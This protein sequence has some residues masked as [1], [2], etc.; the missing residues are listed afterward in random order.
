[1]TGIEPALSAWELACHALPTTVFAAQSK[2]ALSVS[3]RYRPPQ[4]MA[5]G[6]QRARCT[7]EAFW[8]QTS[9]APLLATKRRSTARALMPAWGSHC[10]H[11]LLYLAAV[12]D[13]RRVQEHCQGRIDTGPASLAAPQAATSQHRNPRRQKLKLN[14]DFTLSAPDVTSP[15]VTSRLLCDVDAVRTTLP[16]V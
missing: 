13:D 12:R 3:A 10:A 15:V 7:H 4:T 16:A 9:G 14:C 5:S 2:F 8:M 1:M 11:E 6:T